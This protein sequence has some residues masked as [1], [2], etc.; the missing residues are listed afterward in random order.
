MRMSVYALVLCCTVC[1]SGCVSYNGPTAIYPRMPN[2][3]S[4][5]ADVDELRPTF[6]WEP[7]RT[8]A[9]YELAVYEA[10]N[11]VS[12]NGFTG[13][14]AAMIKG[15]RVYSK[16]GLTTCEHTMEKD[17][18]P[19]S[20]YCWSVRETGGRWMSA[21]RV[22]LGGSRLRNWPVSFYTPGMP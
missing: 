2:F 6:K 22:S 18:K 21:S 5:T 9:T 1:S 7:T 20:L 15:E 8:G 4:A 3:G 14:G 12:W 17:L 11:D 13:L 10:Q 16:T 19:K